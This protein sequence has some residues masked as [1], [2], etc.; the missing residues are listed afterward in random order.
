[1]DP[2]L[3][4]S[5]DRFVVFPIK[6]N[7]IWEMYKKAMASFWVAEE[8]DLYQDLKDWESLNPQERHFI[9]HVLAF[10]SASDV[11]DV[12]LRRGDRRPR[13]SRPDSSDEQPSDRAHAAHRVGRVRNGQVGRRWMLATPKLDHR[14]FGPRVVCQADSDTKVGPDC[15]TQSRGQQV[16]R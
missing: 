14:S 13:D 12:S 16:V 5:Q 7:D 11:R 10:F 15:S 3:T 8:I 1:M 2:I 6:Y 4:E 9:S